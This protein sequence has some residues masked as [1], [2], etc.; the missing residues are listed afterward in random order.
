MNEKRMREMQHILARL[1]FCFETKFR[2]RKRKSGAEKA[3]PQA[4]Q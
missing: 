1:K 2:E 4:K 3:G